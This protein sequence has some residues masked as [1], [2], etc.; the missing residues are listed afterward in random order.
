MNPRKKNNEAVLDVEEF[1]ILLMT[2]STKVDN[3]PNDNK[4]AIYTS[5]ESY[6]WVP[7]ISYLVKETNISSNDRKIFLEL[8]LDAITSHHRAKWSNRVEGLSVILELINS[9]LF[10][11]TREKFKSSLFYDPIEFG[12]SIEDVIDRLERL[13]LIE[14]QFSQPVSNSVFN[15][16]G[17]VPLGF[18]QRTKLGEN[19]LEKINSMMMFY[20]KKNIVAE[21]DF[22]MHYNYYTTWLDFMQ[23]IK[24]FALTDYGVKQNTKI[25]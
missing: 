9:M 6:L 21:S 17:F 7:I 14:E 4:E 1:G 22:D 15:V 12:A 19:M 18:T 13:G 20:A 10:Y 5:K 16:F 11:C 24:N 3:D 23:I 2:C 8:A 25:R